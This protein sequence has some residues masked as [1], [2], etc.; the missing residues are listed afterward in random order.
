MNSCILCSRLIALS[1][2]RKALRRRQRM[3]GA[4]AR[5]CHSLRASISRPSA[6]LARLA[7]VEL[8][9]P[10]P[11]CLNTR[12]DIG[13][14]KPRNSGS[15]LARKGSSTA[16]CNWASTGADLGSAV[17]TSNT[18]ASKTKESGQHRLVRAAPSSESGTR[19]PCTRQLQRPRA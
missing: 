6:L 18:C 5:P 3:R 16:L 17:K 14:G 13:P 15:I 8:H 1:P 12:Y 19:L 11:C 10:D 9:H 4:A 7:S 2:A